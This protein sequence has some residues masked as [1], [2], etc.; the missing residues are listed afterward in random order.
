MTLTVNAMHIGHNKGQL[1]RRETTTTIFLSRHEFPLSPGN[2]NYEALQ[3]D[4]N[5]SQFKNMPLY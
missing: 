2:G 4:D 3:S 5:T 1:T